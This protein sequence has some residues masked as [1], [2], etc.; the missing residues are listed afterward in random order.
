MSWG[1]NY[2]I[3]LFENWSSSP[4]WEGRL[5]IH[6]FL[7]DSTFS[8]Q[9]HGSI[10]HLHFPDRKLGLAFPLGKFPV[11]TC[12]E[13][14]LCWRTALNGVCA[15]LPLRGATLAHR[16]HALSL[17]NA[18]AAPHSQHSSGSLCRGER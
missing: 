7:L 10:C 2:E 16:S 3:K 18:A 11:S 12:A 17:E 15:S 4:S 8:D 13:Y 6:F 9:L 14:S 5:H 1:K